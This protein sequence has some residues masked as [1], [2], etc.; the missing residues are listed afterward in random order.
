MTHTMAESLLQA[1]RQRRAKAMTAAAGA[2]G[3]AAVLL[4]LCALLA[5][6]GAYVLDDSDG[7]GREFDGVGA[8][9]GG[10]VSGGLWMRRGAAVPPHNPPRRSPARGSPRFAAPLQAG[11][12]R[13]VVAAGRPRGCDRRLLGWDEPV[14]A[15]RFNRRGSRGL[16]TGKAGAPTLTVGNGARA[17]PQRALQGVAPGSRGA[18]FWRRGCPKAALAVL[19]PF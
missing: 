15:V 2:A 18:S 1:S 4:L 13:P 10:G 12:S 5:P 17:Q 9:S 19:L 8:V 3:R 14:E 11:A 16:D 6:G 7:L